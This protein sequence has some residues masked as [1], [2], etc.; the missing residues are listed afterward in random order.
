MWLARLKARIGLPQRP[1]VPVVRLHGVIGRIGPRQAGMTLADL[2]PAL[3]RAFAWPG[4]RA[5]ALTIN[6]P[7][8]SPAQSALIAGRIRDLAAD[9]GLPVLAFVEDVAAS[10]GYW[11]ALA[12]DEIRVSEASLVGSIGVIAAGFGFPEALRRLGVERR[13][14][15]AGERKS[16]WDPFQPEKP[17]DVA[18]LAAIQA[19]LH[20]VFAAAVQSRRG[21]RLRGSPELLFSGE[22]WVGARA[23]ELG[24]ADG[25]GEVRAAMRARFGR[26]VRLPVVNPERRRWRVWPRVAADPAEWVSSTLAAVEERATWTRY[27]L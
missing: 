5:V 4:A 12:G 9:G 8:G 13:V 20:R 7:G 6:S 15:T 22:V 11:L 3:D 14:H 1:V 24:L 10:G 21:E 2:A 25:T 27:G 18:R 16:L 26:K 19:D 23:V 17:E